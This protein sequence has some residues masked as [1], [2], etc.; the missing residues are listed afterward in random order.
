MEKKSY[1]NVDRILTGE[2]WDC[3]MQWRNNPENRDLRWRP[4]DINPV[5]SLIFLRYHKST[6]NGENWQTEEKFR[7]KINRPQPDIPGKKRSFFSVGRILLESEWIELNKWR[8]ANPSLAWNKGDEHPFDSNLVFRCYHP[9]NRNGE[10]WIS[11]EAFENFSN[12]REE[13]NQK[14]SQKNKDFPEN[15]KRYIAN[16]KEKYGDDYDVKNKN[17]YTRKRRLVDP[18]YKLK[19][20]VKSSMWRAFKG[21]KSK[22]T[23]ELLGC[24]I[25]EFREYIEKMFEPWMSWDNYGGKKQPSKINEIFDIDH[26]VPL[27]SAQTEEQIIKLCHYTN[28]RPLCAYTNRFIKRDKLDFES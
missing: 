17:E 22:R 21:K 28:L 24:S 8:K 26:I 23:E 4:G 13:R 10:N 1:F 11:T 14:A 6:K 25:L 5:T 27:S 9:S 3:L 15:V 20:N 16:R 19:L 2:E 18:L 7:G 12:R